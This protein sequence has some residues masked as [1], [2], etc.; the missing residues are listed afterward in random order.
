MNPSILIADDEPLLREQLE[1]LIRHNWPDAQI[2]ASVADGEAARIAMQERQPDVAFLDIRMPSP[3]GL[4]L[5]EEFADDP[6]LIVFVTAYD[7][8]AVSAFEKN[9][10]DYLLKPISE[11]R[12]IQSVERLK[13]RLARS[14]TDIAIEAIRREIK[15]L[16]HEPLERIPVHH[17]GETRLVHVSEIRYFKSQ[18]KYT[19]AYDATN[20]YLLSTPLKVLEAQLDQGVFWRIHRNCLVNADLIDSVRRDEDDA[21]L[22]RIVDRAEE[23]RVSRNFRGRFREV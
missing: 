18:D 2:V 17:R 6:I 20:E 21:L 5:A 1:R 19:V 23:L 3:D 13:S 4:A 7:Q 8:Y 12:F 14:D 10:C 9:A 22:L 15:N 16:K 11:D